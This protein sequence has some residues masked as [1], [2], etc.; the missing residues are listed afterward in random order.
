VF[1]LN[2]RLEHSPFHKLRHLKKICRADDFAPVE[3]MVRVNETPKAAKT[4]TDYCF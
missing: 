4:V 1:N 3:G 2:T